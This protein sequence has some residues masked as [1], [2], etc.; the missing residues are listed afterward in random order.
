MTDPTNALRAATEGLVRAHLEILTPEVDDPI[1]PL[2]FSPTEFRIEK[3]NNFAEIPIPGL[4]SPPIQFVRGSSAVLSVEVV[5][6]TSDTLE[7]VREAYT[8]KLQSLLQVI[9]DL[10]APPIV[11]FTWDRR[12]FRGVLESASTNFV[13]FTPDGVPLRAKMTLTIKEYRPIEVQVRE[14][15]TESPDFEKAYTVRA[16][17]TLQSI[18]QWAYRDPQKWRVIA[19]ANAIEDPRTLTPGTTLAVPR[20][21]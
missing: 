16:G 7:D 18:A 1:I 13:L 2:R 4:E 11:A 8:D 15:R 19:A 9:P 21:R 17:D 3:S 12:V 5:L 20:T 10:H 14:M 6:D